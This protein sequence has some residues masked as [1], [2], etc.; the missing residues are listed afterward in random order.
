MTPILDV[1]NIHKRFGELEVLHGISLQ[2]NK[3]DV[4]SLIGSSGSGKSTFLRCINLLEMPEEGEIALSGETIRLQRSKSGLRT[5]SNPRQ[6]QKLRT[7]VS[8]VFQQFNLWSHLS[9]LDNVTEAPLRVQ[10]LSK[11]EAHDIGMEYLNK[12]GIADKAETYPAFLSGGQQQRVAIARALA[13]RPDAILFDEPTS[14]L[15]PELVGEV[16]G[17]MRGLAE[18]GMTMIVVTHEMAFARDVSNKAIFLHQGLIEEQGAPEVLF[19]SPESER[20]QQF[21]ANTSY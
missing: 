13:M 6:I 9:I 20:L 16:L 21:L 8:M 17:V 1:S 4:I 12:V 7:H 14:A 2:A 3:G 15:D 18:E 5:A 19:G 10:G 11:A